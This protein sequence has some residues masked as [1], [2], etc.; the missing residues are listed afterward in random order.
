[1]SGEDMEEMIDRI[2]SLENEK[3]VREDAKPKPRASF[4]PITLFAMITFALSLSLIL[5]MVM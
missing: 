5:T 2:T 3:S 4:N 1:V